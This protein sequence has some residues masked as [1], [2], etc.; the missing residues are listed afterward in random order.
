MWK[1]I[2]MTLFLSATVGMG[3]AF[4]ETITFD[5]QTL[6][7]APKDFSVAL[8]GRGN[9]PKWEVQKAPDGQSGNVVVQTSAET[10][11]YRFPLLVYDKVTAT[12]LDLSVKF[13]ALHG[14]VDQAAGLVWRYRD[15]NNYYIVRAN[16]LEDNVV[17]YKVENGRRIDLPLKGKG[18]TYGAKAPVLKSAWNVLG[19]KVRGEAFVVSLNG[20][21]LYE[22][23]DKTFPA[24][25]K[26]GL[27]TKADSVTMFDDLTITVVK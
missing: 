7:I 12:D 26:V 15:A 10:A 21:Q 13:R 25:G 14:S 9:P 20:A 16:A 1:V 27:W 18:K 11:D 23:E 19:V 24:A 8:T 2:A 17:L 3:T 6:G 4:A 22:V 5:D